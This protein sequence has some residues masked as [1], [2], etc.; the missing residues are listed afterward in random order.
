MSD[1][2]LKQQLAKALVEWRDAGAPVDT[3]VNA[4]EALISDVA[5]ERA[6]QMSSGSCWWE[7]K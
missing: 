4:I 1:S 5:R 3:V 6:K 7:N 2:Y